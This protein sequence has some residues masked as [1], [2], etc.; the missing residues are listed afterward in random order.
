MTKSILNYFVV[1]SLFMADACR[2]KQSQTDSTQTT[3]RPAVSAPT[4][5]ADSA[6]TFVDQQLKFGPRVP[7][8]PAHVQTGNYLVAKFK[9]FGCQVTEQTFTATTWD[10]RK[11]NARNIIA[12]IN[13]QATKRVFISSHWDSR[14]VAD[15]D[16]LEA[17]RTKPVPS[18]NDGASGVGVMLA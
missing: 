12:S 16:S 3:E 11:W 7:N 14:P 1:L 10:G 4:F 9:Q 13:P 17:N 8:S 6:Y 18:A 5:N 15:N 2:T